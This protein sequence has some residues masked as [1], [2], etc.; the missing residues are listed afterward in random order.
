ML[1]CTQLHLKV[2]L[3]FSQLEIPINIQLTR[4]LNTVNPKWLRKVFMIFYL[5]ILETWVA[6][7]KHL[8]ER[9][10][11]RVLTCKFCIRVYSIIQRNSTWCPMKEGLLRCWWHSEVCRTVPAQD[12]YSVFEWINERK[13]KKFFCR[14]IK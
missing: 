14:A 1:L 6:K 13:S 2:H 9:G 5:Q 4:I 11:E 10:P 12:M 8:F 3:A 7:L